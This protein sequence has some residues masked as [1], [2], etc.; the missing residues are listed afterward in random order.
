MPR[1]VVVNTA[2]YA[3][4][5]FH[6]IPEFLL[7]RLSVNISFSILEQAAG[8]IEMYNNN[9]VKMEGE[10]LQL[11]EKT[12]LVSETKKSILHGR[13]LNDFDILD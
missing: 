11:D 12:C 7:S 1:S 3:Y 8:I 13:E 9:K 6:T 2:P 5:P 10:K 4:I